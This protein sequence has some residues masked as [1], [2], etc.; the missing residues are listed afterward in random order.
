M[1]IIRVHILV[2]IK[3]IIL[4][5]TNFLFDHFTTTVVKHSLV[6]LFCNTVCRI[7]IHLLSINNSVSSTKCTMGFRA[8]YFVLWS[9]IWS[10]SH[11]FVISLLDKLSLANGSHIIHIIHLFSHITHH[12]V[13]FG[14][15][16]AKS[17]S[18]TRVLEKWIVLKWIS[19][20]K[21]ASHTKIIH[22]FIHSLNHVISM[23]SHFS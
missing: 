22:H 10:L 16:V 7:F 4:T 23:I 13:H 21:H 2:V 12:F 9:T 1:S 15:H 5:V 14:M 6:A 8:V 19:T 3:R 17:S 18:K 20:S 11:L